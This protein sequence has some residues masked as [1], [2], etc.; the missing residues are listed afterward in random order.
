MGF[1]P[2]PAVLVSYL[3][4]VQHDVLIYIMYMVHLYHV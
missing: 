3:Q 2:A 1:F 4:H